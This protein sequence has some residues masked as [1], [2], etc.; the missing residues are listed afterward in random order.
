MPNAKLHSL[1]TNSD[2]QNLLHKISQHKINS[3]KFNE[4][5]PYLLAESCEF[6]PDKLNVNII[7]KIIISNNIY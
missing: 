1:D 5:R 2:A 6:E 4:L 7:L 3:F